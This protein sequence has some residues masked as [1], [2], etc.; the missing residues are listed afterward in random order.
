V[1]RV[2]YGY[3]LNQKKKKVLNIVTSLSDYRRGFKLV[4]GF[5]ERLQTQLVTI[6]NYNAIVDLDTLL[7]TTAHV[8]P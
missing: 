8:K 5:I 4:T 1:A 7:I 6:S 3:K 2:R